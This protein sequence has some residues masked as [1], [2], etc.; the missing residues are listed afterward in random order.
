MYDWLTLYYSF[1]KHLH[2]HSTFDPIKLYRQP[3][4]VASDTLSYAKLSKRR[5]QEYRNHQEYDA[6]FCRRKDTYNSFG[7][8]GW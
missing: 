6:T 4:K 7:N 2:N 3:E 8:S 1:F 5:R